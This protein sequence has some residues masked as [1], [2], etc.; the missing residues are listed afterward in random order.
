M[1]GS[2]QSTLADD[3]T[4]LVDPM[5]SEQKI[6]AMTAKPF[7]KVMDLA[8]LCLGNVT[9]QELQDALMVIKETYGNKLL[10]FGLNFWE[11]PTLKVAKKINGDQGH[12]DADLVKK[13]NNLL[14]ETIRIQ[15][16]FPSLDLN[17]NRFDSARIAFK[18]RDIIDVISPVN[19]KNIEAEAKFYND[20][21]HYYQQ[22]DAAWESFWLVLVSRILGLKVS[23]QSASETLHALAILGDRRPMTEANTRFV[24]L[25]SGDLNLQS[26]E[27]EEHSAEHF[28]TY[29]LPI[30]P[31][32]NQK[33]T[34]AWRQFFDGQWKDDEETQRFLI[35]WL[36]V[37]LLPFNVGVVLWTFNEG[38]G[39]KTLFN[40]CIRALVSP[41]LCASVTADKFAANFGPEMLLAGDRLTPKKANIVDESTKTIPWNFLKRVADRDA[42]LTIDRKNL[43]AVTIP[44]ST[45]MTFATNTLDVNPQDVEQTFAVRRKTRLVVFPHSFLP[46]EQDDSLGRRMIS[47]LN[48]MSGLMLIELKKMADRGDFTPI[49]SPAMTKWKADWFKSM[50][51]DK[52]PVAKFISDRLEVDKV[53]SVTRR[54][55]LVAFL[56]WGMS[57]ETFQG[58]DKPKRFWKKFKELVPE[59]MGNQIIERKSGND[60]IFDGIK[61]N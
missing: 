24:T 26:F 47:E 61:I 3:I 6:N 18:L 35:Q 40:S 39:G 5:L 57:L 19:D 28:T 2:H 38:S 43:T 17:Q 20:S 52:S 14:T 34:P 9:N 22:F 41:E 46:D 45:K 42:T 4:L 44:I 32:N 16:G 25:I 30:S 49:E 8:N 54:Q 60:Y 12:A 59:M 27:I 58:Y 50:T 15:L 29:Q 53:S 13:I 7:K 55:I 23:S 1:R 48:D 36:A 10:Q 51:I 56:S 33:I 21:K 37:H 31:T 11:L